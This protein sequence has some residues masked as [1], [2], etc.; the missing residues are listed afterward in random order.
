MVMRFEDVN[1]AEIQT[2]SPGMFG[3]GVADYALEHRYAE[4]LWDM[5][6][7]MITSNHDGS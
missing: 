4:L 2:E 1:E 7:E 6:T 3:T 5:A